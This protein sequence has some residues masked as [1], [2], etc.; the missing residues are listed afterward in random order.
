MSRISFSPESDGASVDS[1]FT[2]LSLAAV[3][4]YYAATDSVH[5]RYE[6]FSSGFEED[7]SQMG[8]AQQDIYNAM[9]LQHHPHDLHQ[10]SPASEEALAPWNPEHALWEQVYEDD[11]EF[12]DL[13]EENLHSLA[14]YEQTPFH[15][16]AN[17]YKFARSTPEDVYSLLEYAQ[18]GGYE[19]TTPDQIQFPF[20]DFHLQTTYLG[21]AAIAERLEMYP[22]EPAAKSVHVSKVDT[23]TASNSVGRKRP[24]SRLS[25]K[26]RPPMHTENGPKNKKK[27]YEDLSSA[28]KRNRD[29]RLR[30]IQAK[31]GKPALVCIPEHIR[32]RKQTG[33]WRKARKGDETEV[34]DPRNWS[35]HLLNQLARFSELTEGGLAH[36]QEL[37]LDAVNGRL[38]NADGAKGR[39]SDVA[40]LM[41]NDV[42]RCIDLVQKDRVG[43]RASMPITIEDTPSPAPEP[44]MPFSIVL[45][46]E[47]VEDDDAPEAPSYE[48]HRD[49]YLEYPE[50]E[51]QAHAYIRDQ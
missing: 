5:V 46:I 29:A 17:D 39:H 50:R 34:D 7:F 12:A 43:G 42:K 31:W 3:A 15:E 40:E 32:P 49:V 20:N 45:S 19:F 2:N 51:A 18:I 26:C 24:G 37:M 1:S 14:G 21:D 36:A 33:L 48:G 10:Q 22:L 38:R 41:I 35:D 8:K 4:D 16:L 6:S 47:E 27:G 9:F 44:I 30:A 28:R 13:T 25:G 11:Q 23:T